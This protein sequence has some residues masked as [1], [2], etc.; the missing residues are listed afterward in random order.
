MTVKNPFGKS[1]KPESPYFTLRDY[2]AWEWR[3]LKLYRAPAASVL[4][5]FARAFCLVKSPMV[6]HGELGD[7]YVKDIPG[8]RELLVASL[9]REEIT[10]V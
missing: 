1:R 7:V 2:G 8:L 5:P 10:N 6:P 3:V 4:D 9:R